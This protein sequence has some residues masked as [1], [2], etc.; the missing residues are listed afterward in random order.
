MT[1]TPRLRTLL[2][3]VTVQRVMWSADSCSPIEVTLLPRHDGGEVAL[4]AAPELGAVLP[5]RIFER[6][7]ERDRRGRDD[8]RVGA[9]RRPL[10]RAVVRL[11]GDPRPCPRGC[12]G[13]EDPDLVVIQ[14][15][16]V[17]NR[18]ERAERLAESCIER[19]HGA[20]PVR[21]RVQQLAVDLDLHGRL[22]PQLAVG[23][24]LDEARVVDDPER[25]RVLSLVAT[26]QELE[27]R[28]CTLERQ[29]LALEALHEVAED[30]RID[31]ALEPKAQLLGPDRRVGPAAELG[32]D[33]PARIADG[34]RSDVLVA[35]LPLRD[36]GAVDATLVGERR[37]ADVG[38]IVIR[39]LV[40]D[41]GDRSGEL[42]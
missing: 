29:A 33:E 38:L 15:D 26:N 32:N 4:V 35:P 6:I 9:H 2:P 14:M 12:A 13:A 39:G 10:Q 1:T 42:R 19:V 18:V 20:I 11:D 3:D 8:V 41:L 24:L 30:A 22:G 7:G 21:G 25:R 31:D 36:G 37:S 23:T 5:D 27:R 28:L 17:E 40:R 16:R 34:S